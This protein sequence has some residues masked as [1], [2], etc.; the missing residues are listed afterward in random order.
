MAVSK[1]VY[2]GRT[3]MD[4]TGDSVTEDALVT[5]Y[6][7]HDAAGNA[8]G[9]ANPY[10]KA[11]TDAEVLAQ[12]QLLDEIVE[13]LAKRCVVTEPI[14]QARTV[15][16]TEEVQVVTPDAGYDGLSSVTVEAAQ[17]GE[18]V[19]GWKKSV[20]KLPSGY[21]E[22]EYIWSSGTQYI[23]TGFKPDNNT[24]I[25]ID[26]E[27]IKTASKNF[28]AYGCRVASGNGD[29]SLWYEYS[30][31]T[32]MYSSYGNSSVTL[33]VE[34][35]LS[36]LKI[37]QNK[38]VTTVNGVSFQN[39]ENTFTKKLDLFLF[40]LN[41]NGS[42][43]TSRRITAKLY[44]CQIYDNG[45]LVRDFVPCVNE[46]GT[47]GLYD[48]VNGM[49]YGNAGTGTFNA[50][51]PVARN[52]P[53]GYKQI[54]Y[55]QSSGT[56]YINTGFTPNSN[57]RVILDLDNLATSGI[58]FGS[59]NSRD[60]NTFT[61]WVMSAT[62]VRS[63]YYGTTVSNV[64]GTVSSTTGRYIVD[65][66]KN[67]CSVRGVTITNA[68]STFTGDF[69]LFLF[70]LNAA[71]TAHSS[72]SKMK[73]H[74]CKIYDNGALVRDFI[75]CKN[76]NEVSG[77]YD[78]VNGVFYGNAGSGAFVAGAESEGSANRVVGYVVSDDANAYPDG[79]FLDGY[80]YE[81]LAA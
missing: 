20:S 14:L 68:A 42:E 17:G 47:A 40:S 45:T 5:G 74:S 67:V 35:S 56:Q 31:A 8:V 24:R 59:R 49:F 71:G 61:L 37:D 55:I 51:N 6:T 21:T 48:A 4:L 58:L 53:S 66:N 15:T 12:E 13:E 1:V 3:L 43:D 60:G 57:T 25:V 11:A 75:P 41:A 78:L 70:T 62:S 39:T 26:I 22:V 2:G 28:V 7:A 76:A 9:G 44:S 29:Y 79:A 52:L 30:D 73:L 10:E 38:S 54:E 46:N 69:P 33:I 19:Y 18:G 63:D 32:K 23:N 36:R 64:T 77:L 80:Y 65:K 34:N 72:Y 81:K 16:P 27:A 50:G